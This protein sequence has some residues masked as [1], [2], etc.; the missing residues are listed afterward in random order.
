MRELASTALLLAGLV[1]PVVIFWLLRS[2]AHLNSVTA[3]A[4]GVTTGWALNVAWAYTSEGSSLSQASS[5]TLSI[6]TRF[7]WACPSVLVLVAWLV[8][9]FKTRA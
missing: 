7:G 4:V 2:R 6:A 3:A 5:D 9:H 1:L 8:W